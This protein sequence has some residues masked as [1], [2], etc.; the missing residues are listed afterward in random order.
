[1]EYTSLMKKNQKISTCN[2]LALETLGIYAQNPPRTLFVKVRRKPRVA[3]NTPIERGSDVVHFSR[4]PRF[5]PLE[6]F[7]GFFG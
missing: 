7:L 3:L 4:P 1:M 5:G 2:R 6:I